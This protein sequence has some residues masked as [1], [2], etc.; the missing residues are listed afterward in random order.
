[1]SATART[2]GDPAGSLRDLLGAEAVEDGPAALAAHSLG[3]AAPRTLV[4]PANPEDVARVLKAASAAGWG[5]VPWGGGHAVATGRP[6]QP[7]DIALSTRNLDQIV[8][9]DVDNLT[10]SVQAGMTMLGVQRHLEPHHQ[11]LPLA[12]AGSLQ[13]VGGLIAANPVVPKRLLYGDLRDQLLGLQVAT[14]DGAL[15]RHLSASGS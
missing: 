1:M 15:L 9:H 3:G 4:H 13:T 7:Y 12:L 2:E 5:V 6:P 11:Q 14:G 10:I 8:D